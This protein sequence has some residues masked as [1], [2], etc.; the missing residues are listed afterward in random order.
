MD[1]KKDKKQGRHIAFL[2][3]FVLLL[4]G[5]Q[6]LSAQEKIRETDTIVTEIP[7]PNPPRDVQD[8]TTVS[9]TFGS[10]S[11]LY[12][13]VP[14]N[15]DPPDVNFT[16]YKY[17]HSLKT[18]M[19]SSDVA[20]FSLGYGNFTGTNG[21][22]FQPK[23][24]MF[25][26][27]LT[28]GGKSYIFDTYYNF[29]DQSRLPLEIFIPIRANLMYRT[30][31][32][33]GKFKSKDYRDD[34]EEISTENYY[35]PNLNYGRAG[36]GAG[37]GLRVGVPFPLLKGKK[38]TLLAH[39]VTIPGLF[40]DLSRKAT[41]YMGQNKN[42]EVDLKLGRFMGGDFGFTLGYTNRLQRRSD[43]KPANFGD[44][45]LG[46]LGEADWRPIGKQ[47]MIRFGVNY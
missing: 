35:T 30:M 25:E 14:L 37:V 19:W 12:D 9:M 24:Q 27:Y 6:S 41:P 11:T 28:F 5:V 2:L 36:L 47:H 15:P 4:T 33:E 10:M 40:K 42:L 22:G 13:N 46:I 43:Q 29:G 32:V 38:L 7:Y 8:S 16:M 39:Y 31:S 23:Q 20:T 18:I 45:I 1:S 21:E 3:V 44:I 26:T 34:F 17:N